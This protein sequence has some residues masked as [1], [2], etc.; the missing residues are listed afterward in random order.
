MNKT[1]NR[2]KK[3]FGEDVTLINPEFWDEKQYDDYL[4]LEQQV[5]NQIPSAFSLAK[6][7]LDKNESY[8][9]ISFYSYFDS[10]QRYN[11]ALDDLSFDLYHYDN[12]Y[13]FF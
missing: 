12:N 13:H 10:I 1:I 2:Y 8:S 4:N 11:D 3:I 9:F 7:D 5:E 6:F